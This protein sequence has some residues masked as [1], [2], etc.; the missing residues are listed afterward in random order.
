M[1]IAAL[2]PQSIVN[3]VYRTTVPMH[4]LAQRGHAVHIEERDIGHDLQ[5]L[6]QFD[7]VHVLRLCD[8]PTQ[9]L[10]R[11]LKE[12]GVA[13]LWDND[14]NLTAPEKGNP[15][16][17]LHL[18]EG[19]RIQAAMRAMMVRADV[20][21]TTNAMLAE[22]YRG[23]SG[24]DVRVIEN[25]LPG[26]F[27]PPRERIPHDGVWIGWVAA[28]EHRRDVER[29]RLAE[30]VGDLL[31]RHPQLTFV[32]VGVALGVRSDRYMR[33]PEQRYGD[34]PK[35]LAEFDVGIAPLAD[36][37]FNRGRSNVKLK[38]YAAMGLPWLASP[39][40]PYAGMGEKQGGRL[41]PDDRWREEIEALIT[42]ARARRKLGRNAAKWARGETIESHVDAWER[43]FEDAI[44]AARA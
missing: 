14:D 22:L 13:L 39:I 43:A 30:I 34:L 31:E 4:A 32:T 36:L 41:V 28:A 37:P 1:R 24:A 20:V 6:R 21:T 8:E 38:E 18:R 3:S 33:V 44:R 19:R 5:R 40:G 42:D 11:R 26:T 27:V 2:T 25:Y 10:T 16:Y 7:A 35:V 12:A 15:N 9:I 17:K 29:L 23:A